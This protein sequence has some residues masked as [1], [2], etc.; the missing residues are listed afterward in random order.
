MVSDLE[1]MHFRYSNVHIQSLRAWE[2][3]SINSWPCFNL[4]EEYPE[5]L[6]SF[7]QL[8]NLEQSMQIIS[9]NVHIQS[10]RASRHSNLCSD[11]QE[12]FLEVY[13]ILQKETSGIFH[14][15]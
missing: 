14:S 2:N 10:L 11:L 6:R 15:H 9:S 4:Q 13:V 3:T 5:S 1:S 7:Y 12:N 8:R